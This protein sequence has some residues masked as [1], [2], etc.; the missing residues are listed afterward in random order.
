MRDQRD[1]SY[2]KRQPQSPGFARDDSQIQPADPCD[3]RRSLEEWEAGSSSAEGSRS[4]RNWLARQ[5]AQLRRFIR[6]AITTK[7]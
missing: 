5:I 6:E 4:V 3:L 2:D 1:W 7:Q